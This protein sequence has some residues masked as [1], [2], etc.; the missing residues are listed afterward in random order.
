MSSLAAATASA[1]G[2]RIETMT[3][4]V[5]KTMD[6]SDL[7]GVF[8]NTGQIVL[9][10]LGKLVTL[11]PIVGG[12]VGSLF[13][14]CGSV[15]AT[16]AVA[17]HNKANCKLAAERCRAIAV[18][19]QNCAHEYANASD[20][21][22]YV[23]NLN[24]LLNHVK[25][26]KAMVEKYSTFSKL[27]QFVHSSS[28]HDVYNRINVKISQVLQL[29]SADLGTLA[30]HQNTE[31]LNAMRFNE[32][33]ESMDLLQRKTDDNE[34]NRSQMEGLLRKSYTRQPRTWKSRT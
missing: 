23:S 12:V 17:K 22:K 20:G 14:A 24:Q 5:A 4:D 33:L 25:E 15:Y 32:M 27:K 28:F 31:I 26:M 6:V 21:T 2:Q 10:Q 30:V 8:A 19:I 29:I 16:A 18:I 13:A 9:S 7:E 1:A 3:F 11:V 34:V